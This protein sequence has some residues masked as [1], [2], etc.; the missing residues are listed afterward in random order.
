MN[1]QQLMLVQRLKEGELSLNRFF[2]VKANKNP[3][4]P[5]GYEAHLKTP[6]EMDKEGSTRWGIMGRDF[7]V[8]IDTDDLQ[9][10]E[11]LS[12]VLPETFE[13][14]SPR[15]GLGHKYLVVCGKRD[16][17]VENKHLHLKGILD[18][19]G[20]LKSLGEIRANNW[21][22]VAPGTEITYTD[23]KTGEQK[24]G[25]YTISKNMPIAR[26]EYDDFIEKIKPYIEEGKKGDISQSIT[27]AEMTE[28][29]PEGQR[30]T[31]CLSYAGK[32]VKKLELDAKTA[33]IHLQTWNEKL[34]TPPLPDEEL[35][36]ILKDAYRYASKDLGKP[37]EEI[38]KYGIN[39]QQTPK[40]KEENNDLLD[41]IAD[42]GKE[43]SLDELRDI[44]DS[45][46]KHDN[47]SKLI[48]FLD[49][50]LNYTE[51]DQ[52]NIGYVAESST[53]KSYIP[54][55][56]TPYFPSV[57]VIELGRVNQRRFSMNGEFQ[58]LTH[59]IQEILKKKRST[60]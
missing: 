2:R 10:Y 56:L 55:Q 1:E 34:C 32:L 36:R 47:E 39:P 57:D 46:I 12:K 29:V 5:E 48:T 4:E 54:L 19:K 25:Q 13:I 33:L 45:T 31:K 3:D 40:T 7:L 30:H 18:E 16:K 51:E 43:I 9:I 53:G 44:L 6:E 15:R 8:L 26:M 17:Q 20:K 28:G 27:V 50:L 35:E 22:L 49:M 58:Q 24:T 23:L 41:E 42:D 60:E 11:E 38:I 59:A 52:Q 37:I 14:V 21:Y